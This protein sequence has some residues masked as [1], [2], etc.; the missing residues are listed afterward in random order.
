MKGKSP[1]PCND[2]K[3]E[4]FTH[5]MSTGH[6]MCVRCQGMGIEWKLVP[7]YVKHARWMDR[8]AKRRALMKPCS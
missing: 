7:E 4:G 1:K 6:R 8:W 3:G 5:R 2:C